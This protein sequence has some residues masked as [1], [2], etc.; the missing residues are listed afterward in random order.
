MK[1]LKRFDENFEESKLDS[2][3]N[4]KSI[5]GEFDHN[6]SKL[7]NIGNF[8]EVGGKLNLELSLI[9]E[10]LEVLYPKC[11]IKVVKDTDMELRLLLDDSHI[12]PE[13]GSYTHKTNVNI[14]ILKNDNGKYSLDIN[15]ISGEYGCDEE[16]EDC[17]IEPEMD[18]DIS[19]TKIK[20]RSNNLTIDEMKIVIKDEL[21][22]YIK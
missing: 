10:Y 4:F 20:Y 21:E 7:D 11:E 13:V 8:K 14:D 19:S 12:E 5:G 18:W 22:D 15:G 9:K 2:L 1:H 3:G 6:G 17:D 16:E